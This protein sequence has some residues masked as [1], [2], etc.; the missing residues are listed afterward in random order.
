MSRNSDGEYS[1]AEF[2][3]LRQLVN[4][5]EIDDQ[6]NVRKEILCNLEYGLIQAAVYRNDSIRLIRTESWTSGVKSDVLVQYIK[7][8]IVL[9]NNNELFR[10]DRSIMLGRIN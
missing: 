1:M 8:G 2:V 9:Y 10:P 3:S 7:T 4:S 5:L 6:Q